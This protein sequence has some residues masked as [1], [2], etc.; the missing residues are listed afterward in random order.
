M[1]HDEKQ[2]PEYWQETAASEVARAFFSYPYMLEALGT[3]L[4]VSIDLQKVQR[5]LDVG[6]GKG[7]WARRLAKENPHIDI[8]G[9]DTSLKFIQEAVQRARQDR[10]R[11]LCFY[12]FGTAQS[13]LF[14][15]ESF[16][17]VHIHSPSSFISTA[18]WSPILNEMIRLLKGSGWLNVVDYEH[19]TTSSEAFN[20]LA[21]KGLAGVRA[22]GGSV[23]PSSPTTGIAARLYGFLIDGGLVDVSYTVHAVD[24]GIN[25]HQDAWSFLDDFI[26]D[27]KQFKPFVLKLG[28]M[29]DETFDALLV[30]SK[31][32]FYQ[33][34]FCGY[35]YLVSASGRK[36]P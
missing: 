28:L 3:L 35:G 5:V 8:T 33:P 20:K 18:M 21:A 32:D 30:Q 23:A 4:P 13:L 17:V 26:V 2:W 29:D 34:D 22:L 27:M 10:L 24:Y 7:E 25:G 36:E 31:K 6:C 19:G 12:H 9:I 14:P 1:N 11:S 16:D 15:S